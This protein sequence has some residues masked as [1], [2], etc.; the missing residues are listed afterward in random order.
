LPVVAVVDSGVPGE[1]RIA[2]RYRAQL[3]ADGLE[4]VEAV[5]LDGRGLGDAEV[6]RIQRTQQTG[7]IQRRVGA[8]IHI[9]ADARQVDRVQVITENE[10]GQPVFVD[11]GCQENEWRDALVS[12]TLRSG[13]GVL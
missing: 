1:R 10:R 2:A 4:G 7:E 6:Q 3:L 13:A 11:I 8:A 9:A 5:G 12:E